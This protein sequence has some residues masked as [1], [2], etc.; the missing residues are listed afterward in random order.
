MRR[1]LPL[2]PLSWSSSHRSRRSQF[3]APGSG[4][5]SL[6]VL[7]AASRL[8]AGATPLMT[9]CLF[10][11]RCPSLVSTSLLCPRVSTVRTRFR[12]GSERSQQVAHGR[13]RVGRPPERHS[14][15]H[16]VVVVPPSPA[17][18]DMFRRPELRDHR[19]GGPLRQAE[20]GRYRTH[21]VVGMAG[22]VKE[23]SGVIRQKCPAWLA[24]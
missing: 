7:T 18:P 8:S 21:R 6:T 17:H 11:S 20:R 5:Y 22:Q 23:N 4:H 24:A 12:Y 1:D 10:V 15:V 13:T 3:D 14:R 9:D 19:C 2:T 16:V